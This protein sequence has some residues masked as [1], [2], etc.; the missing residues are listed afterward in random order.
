MVAELVAAEFAGKVDL[1]R[2]EFGRLTVLGYFG[3]RGGKCR[4]HYWSCRCS[5]GNE[6]LVSYGSL[7]SGKQASCGCK[8]G[9]RHGQTRSPIHQTWVSIIGRCTYPS[10]KAYYRYGGRGIKVC[11]RYRA[12]LLALIGDL[13]EQ[14]DPTAT[15]DR[16][17]NDGH[18]S[19]GTCPECLKNGWQSNLRWA[20]RKEQARNTR[21]NRM[22]T[23]RGQTKPAVAWSEELG[24]NQQT[25]L[26][27]LRNG[28]TVEQAL[29]T[30]PVV[31][32]R[33]RNAKILST[34]VDSKER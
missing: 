12:S 26:K 15:I 11:Q 22:V 27:R 7:T 30:P 10:V 2:K 4:N 23:F 14:P 28:W 9:E 3:Y 33:R 31:S 6:L 24:L 18:Y 34:L 16:K 1:T 20:T 21:R 29:T 5:C 32:K 13:G 19:C 17:D 8:R 25:L